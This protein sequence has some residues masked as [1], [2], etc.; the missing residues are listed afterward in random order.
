MYMGAGTSIPDD[1][2][3]TVNPL[4]GTAP[5]D[6]MAYVI[7]DWNSDVYFTRLGA[8][9]GAIGARYKDDPHFAW[10][11]VSSYGNWGEMHLYPFTQPGGPYDTSVQQPITDANAARLVNLNATTFSNKLLVVNSAQTAALTAAVASTSP[12]IG[13]RVDCLG[14]DGLA[15]GQSS[16]MAA[17]GAIDRWKTAP[18]ITEWCQEN[19]GT[20]G[21]D[22]FV[23]GAAQVEQFHIS[24]LSSGNFAADP[25][26]AAEVSAFRAANVG[27]GYR[28]RT[29]SVGVTWSAA[30]KRSLDVA[31]SWVNDN[32]APT[33]LAW[34]AVLGLKGASTIETA[35]R[36]DLRKVMPSTPLADD[37]TLTLATP[38]GPGTYDVYLRVDDAQKVS[39]PMQLAMAGQDSTGA[40]TLG[41]I[42][43]P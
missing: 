6:T 10:V 35:L 29:A 30:D 43:V 3:A 26:S 5:G 19:L 15:G 31:I 12:L 40:Y 23:Q 7:P 22:L 27:A 20:S 16:I 37:E 21:M 14:S 24:M 28:L 39:A 34:N 8:L 38:L 17:T 4:I 2:A 32:V 41:Q 25:Q 18:F 42:T 1:L 9:L 33:Y 36:V 13:L 11:D